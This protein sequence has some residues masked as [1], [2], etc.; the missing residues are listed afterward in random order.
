DHADLTGANL[1]R[2][3]LAAASLVRGDLAN[4][5]LTH[6]FATG[7]TLS[8]AD[9]CGAQLYKA[10]LAGARLD[11]V[12]LDGAMVLGVKGDPAGSGRGRV[13]E[14][15]GGFRLG[16]VAKDMNVVFFRNVKIGVER[17]L[18]DPR[19]KA[20]VH[21]YDNTCSSRSP[22]PAV[23]TRVVETHGQ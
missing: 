6:A 1:T 8:G 5:N 23:L 11:N 21:P 10:N 18:D 16:L 7:A 14:Q 4:A 17:E 19:V 12:D 9:L 3:D 20:S 15:E 2:A 22:L 13:R